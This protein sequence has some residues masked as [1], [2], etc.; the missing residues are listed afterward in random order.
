MAKRFFWLK[1]E[2]QFFKR[3]DMQILKS[4]SN[5]SDY[6]RIYLELMAESIDHD[7]Y[8]RY[9]DSKAYTDTSLAAA[10]GEAVPDFKRAM[11]AFVTQELIT[12]DDDGTILV[13][14]VPDRIG[15]RSDSAQRMAKKRERDSARDPSPC[16]KA[17][18]KSDVT[19]I[20]YSGSSSL[21]P[22]SEGKDEVLNAYRDGIEELGLPTLAWPDTHKQ[23]DALKGLAEKTR[24]LAPDSA[25]PDP[26]EFARG[27]LAVFKRKRET[28]KGE[29]WKGASPEP[30]VIARR[31]GELVTGLGE[32]FERSEVD[33]RGM[34][35]LRRMGK[36]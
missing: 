4:M 29:F 16:D 3:H 33:R 14:L 5:G 11:K 2:R 25:V 27:I 6:V 7:G 31:F 34:E 20:S 8:L 23:Y 26:V 24:L 15:S 12:K 17:L 19:S 35:A 1:L 13:C 9:S 32:E 28:G 36:L 10:I 22:S 30:V 21:P 18:R